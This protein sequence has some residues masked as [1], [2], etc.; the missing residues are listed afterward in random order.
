MRRFVEQIRWKDVVLRFLSPHGDRVER[1]AA[2]QQWTVQQVIVERIAVSDDF[3]LDTRWFAR[4]C[5]A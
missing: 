2:W 3:C 1:C 4:R 5:R